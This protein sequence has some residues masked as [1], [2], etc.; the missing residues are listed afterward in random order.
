M[1]DSK[2]TAYI[3]AKKKVEALRQFYLHIILFV[4][5]NTIIVILNNDVFQGQGDDSAMV[6]L[7]FSFFIWG[8]G[9]VF[10]GLYVLY[11]FKMK[12]NI[13]KRWEEKKIQQLMEKEDL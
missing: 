11:V 10:H 13:L 7:F 6:A 12:S 4:I 3:N 9:L 5:V 2:K 8:I 1:K